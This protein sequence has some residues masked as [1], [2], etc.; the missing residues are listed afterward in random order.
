M[1]TPIALALITMVATVSSA[2]AQT[3][4]VGAPTGQKTLAATMNVY[5]FPNNGQAP[6]QQSKDESACYNWA[7][8]NTG[9]DPFQ[10]ANQEQQQQ[11]VQR[12]QRQD[13]PF[14]H[15]SIVSAAL[16]TSA[17]CATLAAGNNQESP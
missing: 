12:Q 6:S 4:A 10:I 14:G 16:Q 1:R 8:Q 2:Q 9:T 7:V 5:V 11:Q 3:P 15:P 13:D 17:A